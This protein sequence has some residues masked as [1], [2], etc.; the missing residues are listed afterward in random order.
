LLK[1]NAMN[2]PLSKSHVDKLS[3][4]LLRGE[5]VMNGDAIRISKCGILIDGQHRLSAVVKSGVSIET[6]VIDGLDLQSFHTILV[7]L[8]FALSNRSDQA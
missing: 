7:S 8:K 6:I 3:D 1:R 5:W 2:R 4:S